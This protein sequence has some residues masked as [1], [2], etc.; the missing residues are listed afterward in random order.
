MQTDEAMAESHTL[1]ESMR[2][3][4]PDDVIEQEETVGQGTLQREAIKRDRPF[5]IFL[6]DPPDCLFSV[7]IL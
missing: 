3:R 4:D 5:S 7:P 6:W 1:A 2:P